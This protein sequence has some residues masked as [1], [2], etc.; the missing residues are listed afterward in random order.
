MSR[1][2]AS[3]YKSHVPAATEGPG[4]SH[5]PASLLGLLGNADAPGRWCWLSGRDLACRRLRHV[6]VLTLLYSS[7]S[8]SE[9]E[10]LGCPCVPE[11]QKTSQR[12]RASWYV[13]AAS[14][15]V[16]DWKAVSPPWREG[17]VTIRDNVRMCPLG[18][19]KTLPS[20]LKFKDFP[21][22]NGFVQ[23]LFPFL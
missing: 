2:N 19:S 16:V 14:P 17:K 18:C 20:A 23:F 21:S 3:N 13:P 5:C 9:A 15:G 6:D 1:Y 8:L 22:S 10:S 11:I 7:I 4:S 12:A